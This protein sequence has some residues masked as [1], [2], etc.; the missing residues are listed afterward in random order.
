MMKLNKLNEKQEISHHHKLAVPPLLLHAT[1]VEAVAWG[2][3]VAV[4][5]NGD[6]T[7]ELNQLELC[8]E[9]SSPPHRLGVMHVHDEVDDAVDESISANGKIVRKSCHCKCR[10]VMEVV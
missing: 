7:Y 6:N 10:H 5:M 9:R 2:A 4:R 3:Q 1:E 8:N